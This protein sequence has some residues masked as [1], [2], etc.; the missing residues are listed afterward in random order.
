MASVSLR[1]VFGR[2]LPLLGICY[3]WKKS[4]EDGQQG[5]RQNGMDFC[6]VFCPAIFAH[7][8]VLEYIHLFIVSILVY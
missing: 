2:A 7:I 1:L 3:W 4:R 8:V 6:F 5:K